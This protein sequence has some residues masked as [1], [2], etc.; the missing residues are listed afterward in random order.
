MPRDKNDDR[1][2][3]IG[4]AAGEAA[5]EAARIRAMT[6]R[7]G[8]KVAGADVAT[9]PH[10]NGTR[11]QPRTRRSDGEPVRMT[12]VHLPTALIVRVN[13]EAAQRETSFSALVEEAL[14]AHFAARRAG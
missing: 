1:P 5:D 8:R 2:M 14:V 12:S 10:R 3:Q 7:A 13:V 9:L 6:R 11:S 4:G